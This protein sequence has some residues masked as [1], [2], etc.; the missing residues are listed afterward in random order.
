VR[1]RRRIWS[2]RPSL[3]VILS[4]IA[5]MLIIPS[6]AARGVLMAP[7]PLPLRIVG[8]IFVASFALALVLGQVKVALFSRLRMV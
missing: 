4:S 6:M 3:I 1:R 2:S 5:D 7:L 8:G